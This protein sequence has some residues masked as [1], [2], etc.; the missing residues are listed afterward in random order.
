MN[1][2]LKQLLRHPILSYRL[3]KWQV[4]IANGYLK[5]IGKGGLEFPRW[6]LLFVFII[7]CYLRFRGKF[8]YESK[9]E[10]M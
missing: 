1:N 4:G 6:C 5:R 9:N 7:F 2:D 3:F 10:Q 8:P